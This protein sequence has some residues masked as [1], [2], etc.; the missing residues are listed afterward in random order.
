MKKTPLPLWL[1]RPHQLLLLLVGI[2]LPL[3]ALSA[4]AARLPPGQG[5]A[6]E[7]P[8]MLWLHGHSGPFI[9]AVSHLLHRL[10]S[11]PFAVCTALV[12]A[13][14]QRYRHHPSRAFFL[15]SGTLLS[16]AVMAAAK[17]FIQRPRPDFWPH[18]AAVG[19]S[20]FPSGHSTFAAAL[21]ATFIF[22]YW[23]TPKRLA[24][25][26]LALAFAFC[27]GVSRMVLGVHYPSD[28]LAGWLTGAA[29]VT[30]IRYLMGQRP[31]MP[32]S[33]GPA[34]RDTG[35]HSDAEKP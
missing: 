16:A 4:W 32:V 7:K 8:L 25:T 17:S 33:A 34:H 21:A 15:L 18:L 13:A 27:M 35:R 20:S 28:V 10:G 11:P 30:G 14:W 1:P 19:D 23:G 9:L 29:A 3:A 6:L 26:A 22:L 24:V 12:L 5:L 2:V 31:G